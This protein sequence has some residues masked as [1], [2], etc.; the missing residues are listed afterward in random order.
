MTQD[1]VVSPGFGVMGQC[2][3]NV[4]VTQEY[5]EILLLVTI[6][7]LLLFKQNVCIRKFVLLRFSVMRWR[8]RW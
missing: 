7:W 1:P 4:R 3:S 5:Y 2:E 8:W 6:V